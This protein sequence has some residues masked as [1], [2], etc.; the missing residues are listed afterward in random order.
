MSSL[1]AFLQP[2][3]AENEEVI[4]SDRF[5]E[6]GKVVPF[7]IRAIDQDENEEIIKRNTK[8]NKKG[9]EK[10]EQAS[11]VADLVSSS[12]VFPD[13]ND[14]E[15]QRAYGVI[16]ASKLLKKMLLVGE[17]ATLSAKVQK[18]SGI[19][20]DINDEIEEAKN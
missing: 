6:D 20:T 14:S 17:F 2:I 3:K 5:V 18:I 19:D 13:L 12:V 16:G 1:R 8:R 15:L 4:I 10:F 9:E 7:T 11:Y